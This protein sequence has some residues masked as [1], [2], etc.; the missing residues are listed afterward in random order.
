M[1]AGGGLAA[2][3]GTAAGFLKQRLRHRLR[4]SRFG[5]GG[6]CGGRAGITAASNDKIAAD[7]T[8]ECVG[9]I[10]AAELEELAADEVGT[11]SSGA[12][13]KIGTGG[14]DGRPGSSELLPLLHESAWWLLICMVSSKPTC[15]L[16]L[17]MLID[18]RQHRFTDMC[19]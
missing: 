12:P 10:G 3:S 14:N 17:S 15:R 7:A 6:G 18:Y 4:D 16:H 19:T 1:H 13:R 11:A 5:S 8:C 9:G 2:D